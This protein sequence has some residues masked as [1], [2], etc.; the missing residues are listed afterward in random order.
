VSDKKRARV[1]IEA[2]RNLTSEQM[3]S[4]KEQFKSAFG[5]GDLVVLDGG[6][7]VASPL[8]ETTACELIA[9]IGELAEATRELA[10]ITKGLTGVLI[11]DREAE[12]A[13]EPEADDEGISYL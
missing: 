8:R 1:F 5:E 6:M 13:E 10:T 11:Q 9:R 2:N 12:A 4:L 3:A 7:Q